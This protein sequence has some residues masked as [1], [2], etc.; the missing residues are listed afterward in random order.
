MEEGFLSVDFEG[1]VEKAV[2]QASLFIWA[3]IG[4]YGGGLLYQ[5]LW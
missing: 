5:G 1:I 2:G 3:P 4:E